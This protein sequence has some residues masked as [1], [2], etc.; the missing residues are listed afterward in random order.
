[1]SR[2]LYEALQA[3]G[4]VGD[5]NY[6]LLTTHEVDYLN[7]IYQEMVE[8]WGTGGDN[9]KLLHEECH[10]L[11]RKQWR[12]DDSE[13]WYVEDEDGYQCVVLEEFPGSILIERTRAD[14][15]NRTEAIANLLKVLKEL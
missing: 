2:E 11:A 1:M 4:F 5:R 3:K 8:P 10:K 9:E 6:A 12:S 14:G 7:E 15:A 13:I